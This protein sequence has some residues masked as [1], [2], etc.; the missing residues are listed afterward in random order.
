MAVP[1]AQA[2]LKED[3]M[4]FLVI[5]AQRP[6]GLGIAFDGP[7]VTLLFCFANL[8]FLCWS[9]Y[10]E[11]GFGTWDRLRGGPT[12]PTLV[13]G[14]KSV[15][16]VAYLMSMFVFTLVVTIAL[17]KHIEGSL[18]AWL[19]TAFV[20]ALVA[21][22]YGI[23]LYVLL[24]SGSTYIVVSHAGALAL[25][26]FGGAVIPTEHLDGWIR[27]VAA[28]LPQGWAMQAFREASTNGGDLKSVVAPLCV[29]LNFG[30]AFATVAAWRFNPNGHKRPLGG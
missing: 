28:F 3:A 18:A 13:L 24:P 29:L 5:S 6:D 20:V 21:T 10:D 16:S 15:V 27:D 19:L 14:A 22:A 30:V 8:Q 25:A 23:M 2:L 7:G 1:I 26:A 11:H 17:G 12:T 4:D 9:A